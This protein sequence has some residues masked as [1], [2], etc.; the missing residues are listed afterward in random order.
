MRK[1]LQSSIFQLI[2]KTS[3]SLPD[4]VLQALRSYAAQE[5]NDLANQCLRTILENNDLSGRK[6]MPLC[7][8]TGNLLFKVVCP[9]KSDYLGITAAINSAVKEATRAGILRKNSVDPLSSLNTG[10]NIGPGMPQIH[11]APGRRR[12]TE[13]YLLLKG[14]GCENVSR[15]YSLMRD[16][17]A[18]ETSL[19]TI[20]KYILEAV[21]K[22]QG[23]GCSPG[24]LG[25]CVGGDRETGY[26]EAKAQF[27]RKVDDINP[28]P[29][30]AEL[31]T[32][33]LIKAN[34]LKIG[35]MGMG[36][37]TTLL[38]VKI[39]KL[40]R[41]PASLF[42]TV[43]YMCWAFRRQ[44]IRLKDDFSIVSFLY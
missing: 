21:H 42:V 37:D 25:V 10:D 29:E 43:S 16:R 11:F 40:H 33:V 38:G 12:Y 24:F 44:A 3:T 27:W 41:I 13:I 34:Q 20:E 17:I 39:G 2:Q 31:E 28:D 14:G 8:D 30:L 19:E 9:N 32:D 36:G 35:P 15:Q 7:Q 22:A 18:T 26:G 23:Y 6:Q 4:D 1:N 5:T